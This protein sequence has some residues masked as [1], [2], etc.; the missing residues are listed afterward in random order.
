MFFPAMQEVSHALALHRGVMARPKGPTMLDTREDPFTQAG[1][2]SSIRDAFR[3]WEAILDATSS[4]QNLETTP[5]HTGEQVMHYRL[6]TVATRR[7]IFSAFVLLYRLLAAGLLVFVGTFFLV[8]TV[9]WLM[10]RCWMWCEVSVTE[11]ILNAVALGIILDIDD[12]LFDVLATTTGRHLVNQLDPLHMPPLPRIRG[13]DVKS[14]FMTIAIPAITLLAYFTM[15]EPFVTT[16]ESV[17]GAMCGGNQNFV[18][19]LDTRRIIHLSP[20][21][22]GGWEEEEESLRSLAIQEGEDFGFG[23]SLGPLDQVML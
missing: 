12:L 10:D 8:Y 13:A 6:Q 21:A 18:W 2:K 9:P 22:G 1:L 11:L 4:G 20:T 3:Y 15:L 7:K 14:M 17:K 5:R 16:L 23:M 19:A